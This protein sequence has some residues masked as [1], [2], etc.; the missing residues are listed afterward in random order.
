MDC[1][2]M[3]FQHMEYNLGVNMIGADEEYKREQMA[4][5]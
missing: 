4:Q 5:R 3:V 2:T 1:C